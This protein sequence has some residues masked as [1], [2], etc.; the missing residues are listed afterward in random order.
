[1]E[2]IEYSKIIAVEGKDEI[3]F[4]K[5]F[6]KKNEIHDV[7]L[8]DFEGK[9]N[10]STKIMSLNN[11]T[12]FEKVTKIAFIRDA[13]ILLPKSAFDSIVDALKKAKLPYPRTINTFTSTKPSI[14]IFIM[15]GDE[16]KGMLE[17]L[18]LKTIIKKPINTCIEK[19]FECIEEKPKELSKAKILCYLASKTPF[20]N[21]MGLAAL[22][23][24]WDFEAEQFKELKE[25]L[26]NLK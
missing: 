25:F 20:A 9:S 24:H 13:D 11:R 21:S 23:G 7:Q 15:P 22:K 3:N 26:I 18:C 1:M 19:Y 16:N 10:F 17:D 12:G 14:G 8:E 5:A 4:F 6:L 2:S